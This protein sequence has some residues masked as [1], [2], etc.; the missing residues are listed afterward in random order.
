MNGF[1]VTGDQVLVVLAVCLV[2]VLIAVA[3]RVLLAAAVIAGIQWL[4][5][6]YLASNTT[7]VWVALGCARAAGGLHPGR[8]ADRLDRARLVVP[9]P[10]RRWSAM[11]TDN[12]PDDTRR[13]DR[14]PD[15]SAPGAA[16]DKRPSAAVATRPDARLDRPARARSGPQ[17]LHARLRRRRPDGGSTRSRRSGGAAVA[18]PQ[19]RAVPADRGVGADPAV[20]GGAHQR[21]L[22]TADARRRS[23]WG[24]GPA[25]RLGGPRRTGPRAASPPPDGLDHRPDRARPHRRR[26]GPLAGRG[27]ARAGRGA[28]GRARGPQLGAGPARTRWCRRWRGWSG[29]STRCGGR[30]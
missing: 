27:T 20:V 12:I 11:S 13:R 15:A 26:P 1:T 25:D 5:I 9:Q 3:G 2:I 6:H 4:V 30:C 19:Q 14:R 24:S 10:A 29:W 21:P 8:R 28:G 23:R 7:L 22:R 17:L 18:G 16:L